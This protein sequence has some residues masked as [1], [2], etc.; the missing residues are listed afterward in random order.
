MFS[1]HFGVYFL[2]PLAETLRK[3]DFTAKQGREKPLKRGLL[4]DFLII[5]SFQHSTELLCAPFYFPS[6]CHT[7]SSCVWATNPVLPLEMLMDSVFSLSSQTLGLDLLQAFKLKNKEKMF[8]SFLP[9]A[10]L[11]PVVSLGCCAADGEMMPAVSAHEQ[12]TLVIQAGDQRTAWVCKT[13]TLRFNFLELPVF[14]KSIQRQL[15]QRQYAYPVSLKKQQNAIFMG[16]KSVYFHEYRF[17][18]RG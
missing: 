14:L 2:G 5:F 18:L 1:H 3:N 12:L 17:M 7:A 16:I 8:F 15:I 11:G 10:F 13:D 6:L 9:F 4:N